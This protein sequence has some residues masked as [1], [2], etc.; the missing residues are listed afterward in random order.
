MKRILICVFLFN[1]IFLNAQSL[2][3]LRF[4][5]GSDG[6]IPSIYFGNNTVS[7]M[8]PVE[9]TIEGKNYLDAEFIE[10]KKYSYSIINGIHRITIYSEPNIELYLLF[11]DDFGYFSVTSPHKY[12]SGI[13]LRIT[14]EIIPRLPR[15]GGEAWVSEIYNNN[16]TIKTSSFLRE[17]RIEYIGNNLK[18]LF[19]TNPWVEG[20]RD[21]GIG[22]YI[23]FDYS[24]MYFK[25]TNIIVI[26]NGYFS[27]NNPDLYYQ[28]NRVKKIR[29]EEVKGNYRQEFDVMDT[30]NLQSFKLNKSCTNIRIIILDVYYG[31]EYNDTCI[32][33][34]AGI[35]LQ[36]RP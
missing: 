13:L 3:G 9:V 14:D 2:D 19:T 5:T 30:P 27:P 15:G 33:Y 36:L 35:K 10:N 22:E 25:D 24:E 8:Y 4:S 28:N 12:D 21:A 29:I 1:C 16:L 6:P 23:E 17:N 32:N 26:S 7:I 18:H 31:H 11:N 34:L 20:K